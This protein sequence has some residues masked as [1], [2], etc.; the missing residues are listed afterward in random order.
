MWRKL[1]S[2][3]LTMSIASYPFHKLQVLR[4]SGSCSLLRTQFILLSFS[5]LSFVWSWKHSAYS[6]L[7]PQVHPPSFAP[8]SVSNAVLPPTP[9]L[10]PSHDMFNSTFKS[11]LM[12]P[13]QRGHFSWPPHLKGHIL[14]CLL[15]SDPFLLYFSLQYLLVPEIFSFVCLSSVSLP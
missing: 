12:S 7:I 8:P 1:K 10:P 15:D 14:S 11:L 3:L 2:S 6:F 13:P 5:P 9:Q 4:R